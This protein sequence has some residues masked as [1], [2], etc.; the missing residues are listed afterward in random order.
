MRPKLACLLCDG[1]I[2]YGL[3]CTACRTVHYHN[4]P[5][6]HSIE[7]IEQSE[8]FVE[9]EIGSSYS[10]QGNRTKVVIF[11]G[12]RAGYSPKAARSRYRNVD[13]RSFI[14]VDQELMN[15]LWDADKFDKLGKLPLIK[16]LL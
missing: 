11:I 6:G 14:G 4:G 3:H 1:S 5:G 7:D 9:L 13:I 2:G 12:H 8:L 16:P 15:T 10:V